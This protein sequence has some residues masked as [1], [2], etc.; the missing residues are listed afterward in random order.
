MLQ[1]WIPLLLISI[2]AGARP[3]GLA[4][5]EAVPLEGAWAIAG[6]AAALGVGEE[7]W[8]V[9]ADLG[10]GDVRRYA[11]V[12]GNALA[13][14]PA[15]IL[16]EEGGDVDRWQLSF[17]LPDLPGVAYGFD[18]EYLGGDIDRF[19]FD[20][21]AV[22]RIDYGVALGVSV[23]DV[24]ENAPGG[25]RTGVGATYR[26]AGGG[27]ILLEADGISGWDAELIR[28]A[29]ALTDQGFECRAGVIWHEGDRAWT[30]GIGTTP[31]Y[32]LIFDYAWTREAESPN[33][34]RFGVGIRYR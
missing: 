3:D 23:R 34:H 32:R 30:L 7:S 17:V 25:R 21:N 10:S 22:A 15:G 16:L 28:A 14:G 29:L 9:L 27:A 19:S 5:V 1:S 31:Q 18:L 8:A 11:L 24:A 20:L 26:G 4:G 6:N 2:G 12:Q 13:R 33:R